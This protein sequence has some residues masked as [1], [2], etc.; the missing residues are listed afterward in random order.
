MSESTC[1]HKLE[2]TPPS[3]TWRRTARCT[4]PVGH[5]GVHNGDG[6]TWGKFGL[7]P[8]EDATSH[9]D[10]YWVAYYWV[11]YYHDNSAFVPFATEIEALR[12]ALGYQMAVKFARYGDPDWMHGAA[13]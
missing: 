7:P 10:G 5:A 11:A 1:D 6:Y 4:R 13:R 8:T 3:G 12:H 2:W 9:S